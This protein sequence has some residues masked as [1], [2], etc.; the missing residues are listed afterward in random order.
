[1][2]LQPNAENSSLLQTEALASV[3]MA[4]EPLVVWCIAHGI[5]HGQLSRA[6]KHVFFENACQQLQEKNVRVTDS[7]LSLLSGLHKVDIGTFKHVKRLKQSQPYDERLRRQVLQHSVSISPA[8]QVL[9]LWRVLKLPNQ[10]PYK[11]MDTTLVPV[12]HSTAQT[13]GTPHHIQSFSDLVKSAKRTTSQGYSPRLVLQEMKRQGYVMEEEDMVTLCLYDKVQAEQIEHRQKQ[14]FAASHDFLRA[15][16]AN[17][18][19][20]QAPAFLEANLNGDHFS[21]ESVHELQNMARQ[22]WTQALQQIGERAVH[23]NEQ[24]EK[25]GATQR[26][27]FGVY[28]FAEDMPEPEPTPTEELSATP[29]APSVFTFPL[30]GKSPLNK[31]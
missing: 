27:R 17:L 23:L 11:T 16:I 6:L 7:A 1:M 14:F 18:Q 24:D 28:F 22:W 2:R 21:A 19:P 25:Q 15:G 13:G 4:M 29:L 10:L 3:L 31:P 9:A 20:D 8:Q 26:M 12:D 5:G 30:N